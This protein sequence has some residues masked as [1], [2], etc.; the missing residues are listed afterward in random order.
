MTGSSLET[1]VTRGRRPSGRHAR[2]Y[3]ITWDGLDLTEQ[4]EEE[5]LA[6]WS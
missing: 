6:A 2:A 4:R 5:T 3:R 1:L